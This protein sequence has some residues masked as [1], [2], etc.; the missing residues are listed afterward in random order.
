MPSSSKAESHK[1]EFTHKSSIISMPGVSNT[2][3]RK[4]LNVIGNDG[5]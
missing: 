5:N 1:D 2:G 3:K 4:T